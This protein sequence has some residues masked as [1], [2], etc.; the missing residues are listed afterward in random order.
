MKFGTL[1]QVKCFVNQLLN[2]ERLQ[3]MKFLEICFEIWNP[4]K[5]KN[6]CLSITKFGTHS[7]HKIS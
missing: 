6:I 5:R 3:D 1:Q 7:R 4:F 2:L